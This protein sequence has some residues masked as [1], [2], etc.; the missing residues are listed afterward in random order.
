MSTVLLNFPNNAIDRNDEVDFGDEVE[1]Y[2]PLK[3]KCNKTNGKR[4]YLVS[5]NE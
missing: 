3:D 5:L 4:R 1:V 2:N